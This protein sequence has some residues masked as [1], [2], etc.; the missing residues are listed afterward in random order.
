MAAEVERARVQD[1]SVV[2]TWAMRGTL[3]LI[4]A[5]DAGWMIPLFGPVFIRQ[6][7]SRRAELGLTDDVSLRAHQG[8]RDLLADGPLTRA[9]LI[10]PLTKL[11]IPT[12]GQAIAHLLSRAAME[13]L[14]CFGPDR[15]SKP[16]YVLLEDWV[17]VGDPLPVA[18]AHAELARRYLAAY[19]PAAPVDLSA[20]SGLALRDCRAGFDLISD[21][22]VEAEAAG[23]KSWLLRDRLGWLD[24]PV[25]DSLAVRL[26]GGFDTYLLGYRS[27]ELVVLPEQ[28]KR[29]N[30]GGG[31][32]R[33]TLLVNGRAAGTWKM[34]SSK[35]SLSIV[36]EP[37]EPLADAVVSRIDEEVRDLGRF[38]EA[39]AEWTLVGDART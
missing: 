34:K 38:L 19:G 36:I 27:R 32:I 10:D 20:W 12:E 9:E 25:E 11:N 29:I 18:A 8:L 6:N 3:H 14:I 16:T 22:L 30:A 24:S 37:F 7:R 17:P 5:S 15:G 1:R 28:A 13:G 39:V 4:P 31:L 2:R 33:P 23:S 26:L 21:V 35:G